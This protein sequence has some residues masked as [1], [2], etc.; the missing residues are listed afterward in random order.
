MSTACSGPQQEKSNGPISGPQNTRIAFCVLI[1]IGIFHFATIRDGHSWG[2]D[3]A[4]YILHARNIVEGRPY[5]DTGYLGNPYNIDLGLPNYPPLTPLA[6][7]PLYALFGASLV[8]FKTEMVVLLLGALTAIY[9]FVRTREGNFRALAVAAL[10]GLNPYFFDAKNEIGSDFLF[11]LLTYLCFLLIEKAGAHDEK[12]R[13]LGALIGI[14]GYLA[15]ATRSLGA[16][17]LPAAIMLDFKRFRSLRKTT[18]LAVSIAVILICFHGILLRSEVD[19][20]LVLIELFSFRTA[21]LN[22]RQYVAELGILWSNGYSP[23]VQKFFYLL[24]LP[25]AATGLM[26]TFRRRAGI[27]ECFLPLYLAT[28]VLWPANQGIRFLIPLMPLYMNYLLD[29]AEWLIARTGPVRRFV[30]AGLCLTILFT[31]SSA[32]ARKEYGPIRGGIQEPEF[33][34]MVSYVRQHT[35]TEDRFLFRKPRAFTLMTG[36]EAAVYNR[37]EHKARMWEFVRAAGIHYVV[38]PKYDLDFNSGQMDMAAFIDEN[39]EYFVETY[40]NT[41]YS[42]YRIIL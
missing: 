5:G 24:T 41:R 38:V 33:L 26:R 6:L 14:L 29:G 21:V 39:P 2:D 3:F 30:H 19:Y 12:P 10:I 42:V 35:R 32:Y 37:R 22:V 36:R 8:A 11:L 1:V 20:S 28:I 34:R 31:Y 18:L 13:G 27:G 15:Y 9:A 4:Q 40:A 7:A 17:L 16:L 23:I 25:V